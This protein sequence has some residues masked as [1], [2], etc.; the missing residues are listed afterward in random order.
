MDWLSENNKTSLLKT[1]NFHGATPDALF[2]PT[3]YWTGF[4]SSRI[5][6]KQLQYENVKVISLLYRYFNHLLSIFEAL[7]SF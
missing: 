2:Q 4:Y 7:R 3:P 6:L 1:R 5:A